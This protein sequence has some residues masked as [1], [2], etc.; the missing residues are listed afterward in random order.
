[1]RGARAGPRSDERQPQLDEVPPEDELPGLVRGSLV[2]ALLE[3]LDFSAPRVPSRDEVAALLEGEGLPA[4]DSHVDDLSAMIEGFVRSELCARIGRAERVH[5]E[6]PFGFTLGTGGRSLLINGIVDVHATE[7][8]RI[9]VVDYKSN[10]LDGEEPAEITEAAYS[11]Q[12]L[13]Y[14]LAALRA[15]AAEVEVAYVFLE[16]PG[17]PVSATYQAADA[18][19]LESELLGLAEGVLEGRFE[20]TDGPHRALCAGCPGRAALCS[21]DETHTLAEEPPAISLS[22]RPYPYFPGHAPVLH[23]APGSHTSRSRRRGA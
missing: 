21:W 7:G 18:P 13:V 1:M 12:R 15:G 8:E 2:H 11:T 6:L 9:L 16:R 10:R 14:A 4:L 3:K 19:G 22:D 23:R 17:D 5:A 20:P